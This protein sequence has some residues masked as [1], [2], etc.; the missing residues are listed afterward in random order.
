MKVQ[1]L[2]KSLFTSSYNMRKITLAVLTV[3]EYVA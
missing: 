2:L 1:K 3:M